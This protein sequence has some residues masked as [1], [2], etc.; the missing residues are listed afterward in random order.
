MTLSFRNIFL[1]L[2]I[3]LF[4][5]LVFSQKAIE[6]P[7]TNGFTL[8]IALLITVSVA[9]ILFMQNLSL[10]KKVKTKTTELTDTHIKLIESE[11]KIKNLLV[12]L[13]VGVA[14]ISPKGEMLLCNRKFLELASVK[15]LAEKEKQ[16]LKSHGNNRP[17]Q[18]PD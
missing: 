13:H 5:A 16:A 15:N 11:E 2:L 4:L 17:Q 14:V 8:L 1:F 18:H 7:N 10:E 12:D 6:N 3:P 9:V